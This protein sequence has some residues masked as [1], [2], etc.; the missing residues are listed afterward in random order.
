MK[1]YTAMF[2]GRT[3]GAIGIN[4][5]IVA[6]VKGADEAAAR[7]NLYE[8]YEN[9]HGLQLIEVPE[10]DHA[11]LYPDA[12]IRYVP[13][14]RER[15]GLRALATAA[16]GRNTYATPDEARAWID[17]VRKNNNAETI[18]SIF[19][20]VDTFEVCACRCYP[21]HFDP[22]GVYFDEEDVIQR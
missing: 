10:L 14:Y 9:L 2:S 11:A 13:T 3:K 19:G 20:P 4:Y 21:G 5:P 17:A 22:C 7:L 6:G 12:V 15:G 16:Q 8:H 18:R 1:T